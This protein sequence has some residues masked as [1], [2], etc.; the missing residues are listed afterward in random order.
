MKS[1]KK[2]LDME[3]KNMEDYVN[4]Q[5]KKWKTYGWT[6][7]CDGWTSL[8]KLSIINFMIYCKEVQFFLSLLIHI[9]ISKITNTFMVVE[10]RDKG[11]WRSKC[12]VN[13]YRQWINIC[14]G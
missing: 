9:I 6:I 7:M 1:K 2:K 10:G 12:C 14:E 11:S 13:C 5:R 8:T 3:Y 4:L